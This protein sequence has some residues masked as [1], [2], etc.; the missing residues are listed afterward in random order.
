[1]K[2]VLAKTLGYCA[3][4]KKAVDK[5]YSTLDKTK[6][7]NIVMDGPIIHNRSV[8]EDLADKGVQLLKDSADIAGKKVVIRAHGITP[9]A[10][11][12]II[13]KGGELVDGT[14]PIV[15]ASHKK[16]KKYYDDGFFVV[17]SGDKGHAEVIG[18]VGYASDRSVV[19]ANKEDLKNYSY[20]E[21]TLLISQTTFSKPEYLEIESELKKMCPTL[22]S[23]C[24]IC[25]ATKD[26][27]DA[28]KELAKDV[29]AIIIVGGLNSSNT[30]RLKKLAE[31][32]VPAW[33]IEDKKGIPEAIKKYKLVGVSAGAS[34][35]DYVIEEV[36][37]ELGK[38]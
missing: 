34:T 3:G 33:L 17:I 4:V 24:T 9:K 7:S 23:L 11:E 2:V 15:K 21:K 32:F 12:I 38:I 14:C 13:N 19:V 29:D 37:K 5:M 26:R 31:E 1:M 25:N 30:K 36:V 22:K 27:Q 10:E 8:V 18:L 35:P 16:I 6:G 28:V 20:P